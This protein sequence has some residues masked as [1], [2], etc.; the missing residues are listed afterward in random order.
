MK[1]VDGQRFNT[2]PGSLRVGMKV[3][4]D[5]ALGEGRVVRKVTKIVRDPG[6]QS[7]ICVSTDDG[8]ECKTCGL[9]GTPIGGVDGSYLIPVLQGTNR[10]KK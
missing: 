1:R 10:G 2:D 8:G 6:Y 4:S 9:H 5:Y 7:G 3:Q